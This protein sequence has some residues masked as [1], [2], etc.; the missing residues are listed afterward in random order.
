MNI[1]SKNEI[2]DIIVKD[3]VNI[4]NRRV[5]LSKRLEESFDSSLTYFREL[6]AQLSQSS[7]GPF[8]PKTPKLLRKKAVQRIETI[9]ENEIFETTSQRSS[10][11]SFQSANGEEQDQNQTAGG[12]AKRRASKKAAE[13]IYKQS[14]VQNTSLYRQP[15][16]ENNN[17]SVKGKR[18]TRVKRK[19][20]SSGSDDD[21]NNRSAKY[22]KI[23]NTET[24]EST[25]RKTKKKSEQ[26]SRVVEKTKDAENEEDI[27]AEKKKDSFAL[28]QRI[29]RSHSK[30]PQDEEMNKINDEI[31]A[32]TSDTFETS[33]YEDAIGKPIPIMNSTLK[34][35]LSKCDKVMNATVVLER[36]SH[37]KERRLNETV[38][39]KN[40][41]NKR[42]STN[43][44]EKRTST[45]YVDNYN[46][47]ITDDESSPEMKKKKQE[48]KKK[49]KCAT[50]MSSEDEIPNT[51]I[52]TKIAAVNAKGSKTGYKLNALFSPYAEESVK[53]R[54]K[55]FEQAVMNSPTNPVAVDAP[56]RITRTKTRAMIAAATETEVKNTEKNV[57]QIL[58][59]KSIAKAKRI[60]LAKQKKDNEESKE[61]KE[62]PVRLNKLLLNDKI[63]VKQTQQQQ[64]TPLPKTKLP[65]PSSVNRIHTPMNTQNLNYPK[66]LTASR[67][68]I[69]TS[70]ESFI[71]PKSVSKT[72]S[73]E[74]LDEEK[75]K[76]SE[77][78]ARK[79]RDEAL[80]QM[81]EEK[82]RRREQKELK[83]KLAREAKEKQELE[84]RQ[85]AEREKE[86]KAK[87]AL[88]LQ[89]KQ[90]EEIERKRL[91]QLQRAHEKEERRK[92]EE[93]Q[94]LQRLQEQEETERLLAE[95][96][97]REQEAEKRREAELRAQQQAAAETLRQKNLMLAAQAA[98]KQ[99]ATKAEESVKTY[100][101]DS[102]PD[103]DDS[104]DEN[105]PKY[106]VPHWAQAH[107]RK[108]QLVMQQDIPQDLVFKFFDTRKCTPDLSEMFHGIDRSRLKRT[109]SAIWKTPPRI[110]MMERIE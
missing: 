74:Q 107:V 31:V 32:P 98:K 63:G 76:R 67:A 28:P 93:Q 101:L 95:Q 69:I 8:I 35:S 78:D 54:V 52:Q 45:K 24:K 15:N 92:I 81:A 105:K 47:L 83:N 4:Y 56:T 39:L 22:S 102:E 104:D 44:K 110:S 57:A 100:K 64:K 37:E 80:R 65:M 26:V 68:N 14:L 82:K 96:R 97:R 61:N 25:R 3:V 34:L 49:I 17:S 42:N 6:S 84:K 20:S 36:I 18:E 59:R 5:E 73:V 53:K 19:K 50:S 41:S 90:R 77:D 29:L 43:S 23:E 9:P 16:S 79:K 13:K 108:K 89:E 91:V 11:N 86:E 27:I 55:A 87:L 85:K 109:S 48:Y 103:D 70:V 40:R 66:P 62:M 75:K 33:V 99:Q 94:R 10:R 7:S 51:P 12:R 30:T 38:V 1:K 58:A 88:M 21:E 46:G 60:S 71:Q 106:E 72:N 2:R